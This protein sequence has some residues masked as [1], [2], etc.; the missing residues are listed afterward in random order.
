M[1]NNLFKMSP[2]KSPVINKKFQEDEDA[3]RFN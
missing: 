2:T 3:Y 1:Q